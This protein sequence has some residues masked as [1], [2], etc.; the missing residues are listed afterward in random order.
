MRGSGGWIAGPDFCNAKS[1]GPNGAGTDIRDG[2]VG[3]ELGG[4]GVAAGRGVGVSDA[5]GD[6]VGSTVLGV[7]MCASP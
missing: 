2:G 3:V 4:D 5:L 7:A 6:D 1:S